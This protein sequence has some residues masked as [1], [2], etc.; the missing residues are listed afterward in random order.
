M[1]KRGQQER[2]AFE[3]VDGLVVLRNVYVRFNHL[4]D[5]ARRV[6]QVSILRQ[7]DCA[8]AAA[9][10]A[11]HNLV[12]VDEHCARVQLLHLRLAPACA[13]GSHV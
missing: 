10:D 4:F 11:T 5:G 13:F 12:A 9:A 2:F 6:A 3:V 8:H 7:I 1:L